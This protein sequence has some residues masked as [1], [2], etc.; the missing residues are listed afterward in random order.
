MDLN[1]LLNDTYTETN[2]NSF[3]KTMILNQ[4]QLTFL[5]NWIFEESKTTLFVFDGDLDGTSG[6]AIGQNYIDLLNFNKNVF[7][8]FA[9]GNSH[10]FS[11]EQVQN[12]IFSHCNGNPNSELLIVSIDNGSNH[13]S[14]IDQIKDDFPFVK[15]FITDHHVSSDLDSILNSADFYLNPSDMKLKNNDTWVDFTD[16]NGVFTDSNVSGATVFGFLLDELIN[17]NLFFFD[18]QNKTFFTNIEHI[19]S[20]LLK[21]H[22][23]LN[24]VSKKSGKNFKH[25]ACFSQW[26]DLINS[27]QDWNVAFHHQIPELVKSPLFGFAK[28]ESWCSLDD[29]SWAWAWKSEINKLTS[30]FNSTK[31]LGP[32]LVSNPDIDSFLSLFNDS[33]DILDNIPTSKSN[34]DPLYSNGFIQ[35]FNDSLDMWETEIKQFHPHIVLNGW[36]PLKYSFLFFLIKPSFVSQNS[37]FDFMKKISVFKNSL[38]NLLEYSTVSCDLFDSYVCNHP[39]SRGILSVKSFILR[40]KHTI[41]SLAKINDLH[42]SGSFRSEFDFLFDVINSSSLDSGQITLQGHKKAAGASFIIKPGS[43][44]DTL[45]NE[46]NQLLI[47]NGVL[48]LIDECLDETNFSNDELVFDGNPL[49]LLVNP[50]LKNK[51]FEIQNNFFWSQAK[52][53]VF[54]SLHDVQ[55]IGKHFNKKMKSGVGSNNKWW[56]NLWIGVSGKISGFT[57]FSSPANVD[58]DQKLEFYINCSN[59]N[60]HKQISLDLA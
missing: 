32:V 46:L 29:K 52:M 41:F 24:T 11:K 51:I 19:D 6:M 5:H 17:F 12:F 55:S 50:D 43:S 30:I 42:F 16:K 3:K 9:W 20:F 39:D 14:V 45:L 48:T 15:V 54:M 57:D 18:N 59:F 35:W 21:K 22:N 10:G 13:S 36:N 47:K 7:F 1:K 58:F 26:G 28:N 53:S 44:L 23:I 8:E 2:E 33:L 27:G 37:N 49:D 34:V 4:P 31:R 38:L 56:F 40:S 25:F 60:N